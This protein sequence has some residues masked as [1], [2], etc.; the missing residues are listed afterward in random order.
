MKKEKVYLCMIKISKQSRH[1]V[2]INEA[3]KE[4][5]DRCICCGRTIVC[6]NPTVGPICPSCLSK[7]VESQKKKIKL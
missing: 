3:F 1:K 5:D 6:Y 7:G 4:Q 2:D